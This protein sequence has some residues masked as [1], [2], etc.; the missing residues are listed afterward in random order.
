MFHVLRTYAS[1]QLEAGESIVSLSVWLG[2]ASPKIT[3]DR[4]AR[5]M[6][7]GWSTR[8]RRHGFAAGTGPAA[9]CP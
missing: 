4:Y 5:F 6:P 2:H 1:V 8:P 7:G 9:D 3:L